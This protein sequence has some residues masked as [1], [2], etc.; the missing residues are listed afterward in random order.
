M[1]KYNNRLT[2]QLDLGG[3]S[4]TIYDRSGA[5]LTSGTADFP[6]NTS[7]RH[8]DAVLN[9]AF[10]SVSVYCPTS[11]YTLVPSEYYSREEAVKVL[12][13]LKTIGIDERVDTLDLPGQKSVMIYAI[14]DDFISSIKEYQKDAKFYPLAYDLIDRIPSLS[15]NNRIIC[16]FTQGQVHIVASERDKLLFV[17]SFPAE[18]M[19]TAQYFIFSVAR[20]VLFNPEHTY[21]YIL[22]TALEQMREQLLKYFA[23]VSYLQ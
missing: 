22:G 5:V 6:I 2:I 1:S 8:I 16:A 3:F 12:S 4:F 20:Q 13:S 18:D 9:G 11:K 21:I 7:D 17:N 23:E 10:S 19:I 15:H 14:Q